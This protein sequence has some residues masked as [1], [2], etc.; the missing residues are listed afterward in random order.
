MVTRGRFLAPVGAPA[1]RQTQRSSHGRPA[2]RIDDDPSMSIDSS[3]ASTPASREE[4]E[5]HALRLQALERYRLLVARL[6]ELI[7]K[8]ER[9]GG[10]LGRLADGLVGGPAVYRVALAIRRMATG[11]GLPEPAQDEAMLR[12]R[13]VAGGLGWRLR[14]RSEPARLRARFRRPAMLPLREEAAALVRSMAGGTTAGCVLPPVDWYL[15]GPEAAR[16][17]EAARLRAATH[18][19]ALRVKPITGGFS[20]AVRAASRESCGLVLI[21]RA[22]LGEGPDWLCRLVEVIEEDNRVAAVAPVVTSASGVALAGGRRFSLRDQAVVLVAD[23]RP[24]PMPALDGRSLLLAAGA[25]QTGDPEAE[26]AGGLGGVDLTL[27]LSEARRRIVL[28]DVR[29]S[30]ADSSE[31]EEGAAF[32]ARWGPH[33][34]RKLLREAPESRTCSISSEGQKVSPPAGNPSVLDHLAVALR[35]AARDWDVAR[36]GGDL[37]LA[38]AFARA[39]R[40]QGVRSVIEISG[41]PCEKAACCD[42]LVDL[43]GREPSLQRPGQLSIVWLISHPSDVPIEELSRA[44]LVLAASRSHAALLSTVLPVPVR[45]FLQFTDAR[46]FQP[47]PDPR[48][49]H[50]I[51]FVGNW[52]SVVRPVIWHALSTS[53]DLA[54]Y[55]RG[56]RFVAPERTV[57]EWL[58]QSELPAAYSSCDLLLNDHWDDMRRLGYL[59]NRLFDALACEAFVLS[60]DVI[61]LRDELGDAVETYADA[62]E[63]PAKIEYWLG[64]P[65][66]RRARA[67][68]GRAVVL[69][70]H[71]ADIRVRQL[72]ELVVPMLTARQCI[73]V[74]GAR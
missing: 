61:G 63:L 65:A 12:M 72:L 27:G 25:V 1:R 36:H 58:P 66:E 42:V 6:E 5:Q 28:A 30:S 19:P 40:D 29:V 7:E 59:S 50:E 37:Y 13:L 32:L 3:G 60:D 18:Y 52:R 54:L 57:A 24:A 44:D 35:V 51:L 10:V 11:R 39:L 33:L 49:H 47:R 34:R 56:W 70:R 55:G 46:H 14:V 67:Q 69:E 53:R 15:W 38:E 20:A 45:P 64:R 41:L 48:R 23:C 22:V 73:S 74:R 17:L 16:P 9:A 31:P 2:A 26:F 71:T 4:A 62:T 43:R 8:T 68:R 21:S